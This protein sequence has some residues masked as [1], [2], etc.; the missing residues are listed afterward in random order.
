MMSGSCLACSATKVP[1]RLSEHSF[2]QQNDS[3]PPR[4][5]PQAWHGAVPVR[6]PDPSWG[7]QQKPP[8]L[9]GG[10]QTTCSERY[11]GL[12]REG[13]AFLS[14]QIRQKKY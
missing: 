11:K 13:Q 14:D 7:W 10:H 8:A 9:G 3:A 6:D 12:S 1:A 2:L 5:E 4:G